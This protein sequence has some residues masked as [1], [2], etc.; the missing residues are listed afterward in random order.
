MQNYLRKK[1]EA[2]FTLIELLIVI[3][4][5]GI[6]ATIL[7]PELLDALRKAKQK[8][9]VGDMR[10]IGVGMFEWVTD[11]G[12]AAAAGGGGKKGGGATDWDPTTYTEITHGDLENL[13]V[14]CEGTTPCPNDAKGL[15]QYL[16]NLPSTDGWG[17]D[18]VF[19]LNEKNPLSANTAAIFSCGEPAPGATGSTCTAQTTASIAFFG[20][21]YQQDIVWADGTFAAFPVG[22]TQAENANGGTLPAC[23]PGVA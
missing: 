18:F 17:R 21:C 9:T 5:I 20:N 14:L 2:G 22:K 15:V 3:A 10:T 8:D 1:R 19:Y 12:G 23:D 4:I 7:I 6:I 11:E 16:Q 13:L